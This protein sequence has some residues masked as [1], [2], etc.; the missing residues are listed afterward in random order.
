MNYEEAVKRAEILVSQMTAEEK[1]SQLL[2]NSPAIDRLKISSYNWWNEACH[3]V[4]RAGVATVFPQSIGMAASF[5]PSLVNEVAQAIST[6][7]RAKYNKSV[8]HGDRDIYKGLTYW[9]PNINIFRDPRWG[10]GQETCGEDPFL[11]SQIAKAYIKGLQGDG[12]F[13]KAASCA[14]HFAA[15]SG[16]EGERH[17]FDARVTQKDLHETYLPAF[18][19]A[20]EC[21]VAGVMGAYNRTN[22]E[23]CCANSYLMDILRNQWN[24]KGYFVSDCGAINDIY[25][26]HKFTDSLEK[27]AAT[28]LKAGCNL[29]CGEAFLALRDAYKHGLI[30]DEEITSAAVRLFTIRVMLGEFEENRPYSDIPY[31]A[32]SCEE[33]KA[34]N[35]KAAEET[36]VLLENKNSYLPLDKNS[37]MKIAVVGPNSMSRLALEGN[38]NGHADEYVTVADGIRRVFKNA[39]VTVADG[40]AIRGIN[41]ARWNEFSELLSEGAAAAEEADLTVLC[42]GLD[43]TIEGEDLGFGNDFTDCGDRVSMALPENQQRLAEAVCEVCDNVIVVVLCGSCADLGGKVRNKAKAVIHGWYPGAMGGLAVANLIAGEFSPSGRLPI[44][45]YHANDELPDISDYSMKNRTYRFLNS[46][47][48]YPFG[49]GLS[50]T[51]FEFN[52]PT[53]VKND[54]KTAVISVEV[55]NTGDFDSAIKV[56]CY[57]HYDDSRTETPKL[58]LCG[59]TPLCL[60]QGETKTAEIIIDKYWLKAV[61]ESGERVTPDGKITL[62]LGDG[63]PDADNNTGAIEL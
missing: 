30:G 59:I 63:Q 12:E 7:G 35:L 52:N 62:Y 28:A 60:K 20:V 6:E 23:P 22:G 13:L 38:Y 32:V 48:L 41:S 39:S 3:G 44:T 46:K 49:Y 26:G 27:A 25:E 33:H 37:K 11:T 53:V 31:S 17:S 34:L 5:N 16:P 43:R 45:F 51:T 14:K 57:A 24:F 2:F 21:G 40:A 29:N 8:A 15:H 18:E 9:A 56:Q 47:P 1:M 10:R 50:F 36:L 55:S 58:Q 61:L 19:K 42:L 4:A 54:S